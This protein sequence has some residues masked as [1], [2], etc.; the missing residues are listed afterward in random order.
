M[1]DN[2]TEEEASLILRRGNTA[3]EDIIYVRRIHIQIF[4]EMSTPSVLSRLIFS[5]GKV[6]LIDGWFSKSIAELAEET[7]LSERTVHNVKIKLVDMGLVETKVTAPTGLPVLQWRLC[8]KALLHLELEFIGE[9][10]RLI[11]CKENKQ[12]ATIAECLETKQTANFAVWSDPNLPIID[13]GLMASTD[14]NQAALQGYPDEG[15]S[16]H[17][18]EKAGNKLQPLQEQTYI[19]HSNVYYSKK[20]HNNKQIG[21]GGKGG[22]QQ[23]RRRTVREV[24]IPEWMPTSEWD[25]FIKMRLSSGVFTDDAAMLAIGK[26]KSMTENGSDVGNGTAAEILNQSVFNSWKGLFPLKNEGRDDGKNKLYLGKDAAQSGSKTRSTK[27][28][29]LHQEEA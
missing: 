24:I 22:N 29:G 12:T 21:E 1:L 8:S 2:L 16:V 18:N 27:Y 23:K 14:D 17:D 20:E 19:L 5:A 4:K 28:A 7:S 11:K 9:L 25:A 6:A 26:L 3:H 13:D 15:V 10:G